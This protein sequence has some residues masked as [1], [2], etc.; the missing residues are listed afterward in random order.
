MRRLVVVAGIAAA[1]LAVATLTLDRAFLLPLGPATDLS[2]VVVDR[3]GASLRVF[4]NGAGRW[5]LPATAGEVAPLYLRMLLAVEDR[6]F[7]AHPG[8]DPLAMARASW[9]NLVAGR[10]VSGAS[11]LSMQVARLLEPRPRTLRSKLL[12]ALRALQLEARLG[13][14]GVLDLYLVLAPFGGNLDGV[15]AASRAYFGKEP[16]ALDPAEAALLVALPRSPSRLRPDRHPDAARAA[17][18]AVLARAEAAGVID[19]ATRAEAMAAPVPSARL[20]WPFTAPHLARRAL[21]ARPGAAVVRTTV[22]GDLQRAVE[23]LARE[24]ASGLVPQAGLAALVVDNRHREI[25]V[26]I[27]APDHFSLPRHGAIDMTLAVRSPGS[28]LKPFIYGMAF[29]ERIV[30]PVTLVQDVSTRFGDYAP[31][32]FDTSFHGELTIADALLRS[33]NVPAVLVLHRLGPQRFVRAL[34]RAGVALDPGGD[35]TMP[36]LPV[37]LGGVGTTLHDLAT[38]YVALARGGQVAP[39]RLLTDEPAGP[40]VPLLSRDAARELHRILAAARPA[41]GLVPGGQRAGRPAIA[42]KTGT[43]YGFRDAWAM[44]VTDR[45]TVGV[46]VG[47][48]DG[49]PIPEQTGRT[50]ALPLLERIFDLLPES[51]GEA[52]MLRAPVPPPDLLRRIEALGPGEGA[53]RL[54]DPD[55]LRLVFPEAGI[56]LDARDENGALAPVTAIAAGGRRPLAWL[57]DG[58]PVPGAMGREVAFVPT[59]A[60][61]L[62]ITVLDAQGRSA[63]AEVTVR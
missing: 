48:P 44:G 46:W 32:N 30:T 11:T 3:D 36:G 20:P 13:K 62:R 53:V 45:Y 59:R 58:A 35:R 22:D 12:E 42:V 19:A 39:L 16:G 49:T 28:T 17:R 25:R 37:A 57:V 9:Q 63:S 41:P 18:D 50:A 14:T 24:A 5:R 38:L 51:G 55:R 23:A 52:A 21:A 60:G 6:R 10:T 61:S 7:K 54:S 34:A 4:A 29:D 43:S 40:E 2:R 27:G 31:R 26:A 15:R 33:L 47:R 8:I 1:A 56:V